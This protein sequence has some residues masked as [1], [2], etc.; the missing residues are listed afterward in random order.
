ETDARDRKGC[1]PLQKAARLVCSRTAELLLKHGADANNKD[2]CGFTPL[3]ESASHGTVYVAELLLKIGA[4]IDDPHAKGGTPLHEAAAKGHA[5]FARFL[6]TAGASTSSA[7]SH[8]NTP[9]HIAVGSGKTLIA[10][11]LLQ[12]GSDVNSLNMRSQTPLH[13]A[14]L[15]DFAALEEVQSLLCDMTAKDALL[16]KLDALPEATAIIELLLKAGADPRAK[17]KDGKTPHAIARKGNKEILW[18]AMMEAP[19]K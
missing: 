4:L 17:D 3:H 13:L 10:D 14:A 12:F 6:L 2:T 16:K 18:K 11:L 7:D 8:G 5:D 1:T 15:A 19:L 9:L